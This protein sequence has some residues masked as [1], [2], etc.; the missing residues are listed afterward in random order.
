MKQMNVSRI[1]ISVLPRILKHQAEDASSRTSLSQTSSIF[2]A[3]GSDLTSLF[4]CFLPPAFGCF[5]V[6]TSVTAGALE[7]NASDC[8][9]CFTTCRGDG[10]LLRLRLTLGRVGVESRAILRWLSESGSGCCR[11]ALV[12]GVDLTRVAL[13]AHGEFTLLPGECTPGLARLWSRGRERAL[14]VPAAPADN[15]PLGRALPKPTCFAG[16]LC[17]ASAALCGCG[18]RWRGIC[19]A[20]RNAGA[21]LCASTSRCFRSAVRA[22][23]ASFT[24]TRKSSRSRSFCRF[25]SAISR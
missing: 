16:E 5:C 19:D 15:L 3:S 23:F 18:E 7:P 13:A 4:S 6:A 1:P 21:L 10:E 12:G 17:T 8:A 11:R 2:S 9:T 24:A 22:S 20:T 25:V 14:C